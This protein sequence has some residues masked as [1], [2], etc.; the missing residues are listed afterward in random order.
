MEKIAL[1]KCDK[2]DVGLIESKIRQG[3]ISLGG[4]EFIRKLIPYNSKVLLKPNLLLAEPKDSP[5]VTNYK[6]FEAVIRVLKDYTH[7]ISFG[8]SPGF[9]SGF[10]AAEKCGL[11]EVAKKY[12]V[13]FS[14]FNEYTRVEFS[15]GILCKSWEVS[16]VAYECDCLITLP[17][18]KTHGMMYYTGAIKNQ[19]GC[20]PGT[21]KAV[22][23][24][25]M[26][27]NENFSTMLLDLNSLLDTKF[28]I[29]DGIIG[30]ECNG[31]RNGKAK[32]I[33]TIIMG[34]SLS[35]VDSTAVKLI[36]YNN[37]LD[38]PQFRIVNEKKWGAVLERDIEVIGESIGEM[39]ID[40][41][42][43]VRENREVFGNKYSLN[44]LRNSLAPYPKLVYDNCIS[45]N[46]CYEICPEKPNVI[47]MVD[48]KGKSVPAFDKKECIRCFCCQEM[49]PVG[50]IK[51]Q[52]PILRRVLK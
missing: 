25:R 8:D 19:F 24:A 44:F 26:K 41:F 46:R 17:K 2:Y 20:V 18:L 49:C 5:V 33:D 29:L 32:K 3:F 51:V 1:L 4:E 42:E 23:H 38:I 37:P 48:K 28:A 40:D 22:W 34:E 7:N 52:E 13:K 9:G 16:T 27:N 31:P 45:C 47:K 21:R 36:G 39:K 43:L 30:M 35:A 50:A 11:I 14:D 6:F 15:E 12:N 10:K